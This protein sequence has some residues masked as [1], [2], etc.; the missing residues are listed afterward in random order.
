MKEVSQFLV[1]GVVTQVQDMC[2]MKGAPVVQLAVACG[3]DY[4]R[5]GS[6]CRVEVYD[7]ALQG[8]AHALRRG[9]AVQ[10]AGRLSG[11]LN[12]R[13][14]YNYSLY[15]DAILVVPVAGGAGAAR[16]VAQPPAAAAAVGGLKPPASMDAAPA[17]AAA[18]ED[19]PF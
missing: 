12:D 4:S 2:T 16:P 15:A 9:Q 8:A 11:R 5:A 10:V 14:Y 3:G 18:D 7:A 6:V 13:G 1:R 17:G 19:I